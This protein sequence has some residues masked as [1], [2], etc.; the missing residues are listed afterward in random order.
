MPL[1]PNLA[2]SLRGRRTIVLSDAKP[3]ESPADPFLNAN[4]GQRSTA[5]PSE[6]A[7]PHLMPNTSRGFAGHQ[8][9]TPFTTPS[10][11]FEIH[12]V[13]QASPAQTGHAYYAHS[14]LGSLE[15]HQSTWESIQ[16]NGEGRIT[17]ENEAGGYPQLHTSSSAPPSSVV[18][19]YDQQQQQVSFS[20]SSSLQSTRRQHSPSALETP[21]LH[22]LLVRLEES[23]WESSVLAGIEKDPSLTHSWIYGDALPFLGSSDW[24]KHVH[25]W[26]PNHPTITGQGYEPNGGHYI[27]LTL[28]N[29]GNLDNRAVQDVKL[30]LTII[31]RERSRIRKEKN[32]EVV[33]C[34]DYLR[35]LTVKLS[36]G[37]IMRVPDG[38]YQARQI[39]SQ[40]QAMAASEENTVFDPMHHDHTSLAWPPASFH[41]CNQ[42]QVPSFRTLPELL[43]GSSG[44]IAS[45]A[46]SPE[47]LPMA[48]TLWN[49]DN[50]DQS[51][52]SYKAGD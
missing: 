44:V 13:H 18:R 24:K 19:S 11:Q 33:L 45:S 48:T 12:S 20:S 6:Y 43:L 32:V 4:S 14:S 5:N 10:S 17:G 39:N 29:K 26:P 15:P 49:Q 22:T 27:S 3:Q 38:G 50:R 30:A 37:S 28:R 34:Q 52:R 9:T 2:R 21:D 16:A 42:L 46:T 25:P 40:S 7:P 1:N 8:G 47:G 35:Q 36:M 31:N 51:N 41:A 23:R